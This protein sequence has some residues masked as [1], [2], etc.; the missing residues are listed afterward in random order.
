MMDMIERVARVL[1]FQY[2]RHET[3]WQEWRED[4]IA[5]LE[6]MREP[7]A[8]MVAADVPYEHTAPSGELMIMTDSATKYGI[9]RSIIDEALK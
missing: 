3:N 9:W 1:A 2:T 4:A 6:E 5:V 7:T 8:A